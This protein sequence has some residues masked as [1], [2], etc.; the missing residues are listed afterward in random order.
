MAKKYLEKN[1]LEAS[2]ERLEIMFENFDNINISVSGGK[3]STDMV[4]L[5]KREAK[6]RFL[7]YSFTNSLT[8]CCISLTT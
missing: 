2:I 7:S 6:Q 5:A 8:K 3:D 4:Q 1:V